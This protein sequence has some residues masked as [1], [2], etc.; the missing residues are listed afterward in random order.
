MLTLVLSASGSLAHAENDSSELS[1]VQTTGTAAEAFSPDALIGHHQRIENESFSN[2]FTLLPDLLQ[3]QSG[4]DIRSVGGI[5]QFSSPVIRGSTGQQVLVFWDGLLINSINGGS[6]DLGAV[7]LA[8]ASSVDIYRGTVPVELASSAVGGAIHIHSA[9]LSSGNGEPT[10]QVNATLGS[11][12]TQ[13]L[14]VSQQLHS[15]HSQWLLSAET[16][17]ADNDF[18]YLESQP[19]ADPQHP[20]YEKRYNN[21]SEQYHWLLKGKHQLGKSRLDIALQATNSNRQLSSKI[22]FSG[23]DAHINSKD[24]NLQWRWQYPWSGDIKSEIQGSFYRQD[25]T[26][27][28]QNSTIGLG[29]Q[30]NDYLTHG[31]Q[32]QFNQYVNY[33][34][35]AGV[36]TARI[37][38][39]RS[40]TEY[41]LLSDEEAEQQCL[42]GHGCETDYRRTQQDIG[43]RLQY[44]LLQNLISLQVS[45]IALTDNNP[46][47]SD[48]HRLFSGQT[49]S[50]AISHAFG[51][52]LN[53]Y[54]S[55]ARQLR[56]PATNELFGDRGSSIGNPDLL[57]E[58]SHQYETGVN[59]QNSHWVI[60]SSLYWRDLQDAIIAESDSRGVLR[61]SNIGRG[62]HTGFEQDILWQPIQALTLKAAFTAQ[63]NEI[64]EYRTIPYYEGNQAAGYSRFY[65]FLSAGWQLRNWLFSLSNETQNGGYYNNSNLL[66]KDP[67]NRWSSAITYRQP[68]WLISLSVNDMTSDRARDFP[69]Y[70]EPG[71]MYF[72]KTHFEW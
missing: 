34:D 60:S 33:G 6:A 10:G 65:T 46:D 3:Q 55:S 68:R 39:E 21:G 37:L 42:A 62:T 9:D 1:V 13:Q 49:W 44:Q 17:S 4:I 36:L 19:V 53:F 43:T 59:F 66:K 14:S 52:G 35:F 25:Q 51:S 16:L 27:D 12:G 32:F 56:L 22:N 57:P 41:R 71:R 20:A 69:Q 58:K 24:R 30:L 7:S 5:G 31:Q 67:V 54:L 23:N 61:Y 47:A 11:Y 28:D 70:P 26:Y 2:T 15:E 48:T 29:Q 45:H 18:T 8:Q 64:T 50:A 38:K 63:S 72:L 40:A